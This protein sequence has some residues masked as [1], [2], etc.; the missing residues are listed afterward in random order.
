MCISIARW[1]R[2]RS[3]GPSL[4]PQ[5]SDHRVAPLEKRETGSGNRFA[6]KSVTA[7]PAG[8][9]FPLRGNGYLAGGLRIVTSRS[10][11]YMFIRRPGLHRSPISRRSRSLDGAQSHPW[12]MSCETRAMRLLCKG[13]SL[14]VHGA[15]GLNAATPRPGITP[16]SA[17]N[18]V[19]THAPDRR[20]G[21]G[22]GRPLS[23]R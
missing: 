1:D 22:T 20:A 17:Q 13:D 3:A 23:S 6:E 8:R 2:Q 9:M 11:H 4:A 12:G 10:I 7:P 14:W 21:S 16:G 5:T 15:S 19:Y 18:A